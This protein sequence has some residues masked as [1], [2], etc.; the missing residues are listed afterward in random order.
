MTKNFFSGLSGIQLPLRKYEFPPEYQAGSRLTYYASL[1]NSIEVNSSFYKIPQEK[2]VSRWAREVPDDFRFT[3][4]LFKGITHCKDLEFDEQLV[5]D[6]IQSISMASAKKGCILI[7]F[8][9]SLT[10]SFIE[11]LALL[12]D[13]V[14]R[15]NHASWK[16]AVEF[17]NKS[18]YLPRVYE[19]LDSFG[20][21]MVIQDIPKSATPLRQVM[22]D[23]VYVRFHGP[24]GNYKGSYSDAFLSEYASYVSEWLSEGK[25]VFVYFN[26]T[27]GGDAYRNLVTFNKMMHGG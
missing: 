26:N 4:K 16:V 18:W 21:T 14:N 2:T 8:P 27:N 11:H 13:L 19:L 9:P 5:A 12:L 7:Q 1:F 23:I 15:H 22:S 6:F 17:R 24:A 25:M 3:F 10:S 20:A